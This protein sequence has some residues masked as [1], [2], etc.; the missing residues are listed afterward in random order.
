MSMI[1]NNPKVVNSVDKWGFTALHGVAGEEHFAV[2]EYLIAN[3]A[4]LNAKN[5][6]G[7]APLHL[8]A[9][10]K[11]VELLVSH[12]AK[13]DARDNSGRTPLIVHA[14]EAESCDV[15]AT[16]LRLGADFE[17]TDDHGKTALAISIARDEEDKIELLAS[18]RGG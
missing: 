1:E 10:P 18:Y 7:I 15:M 17:A 2:A 3:G 4:D 5:A 6:D 14:A 16:L 12:G 8:A 9:W 11:M 13:I